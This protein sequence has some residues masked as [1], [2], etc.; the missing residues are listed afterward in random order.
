MD[1]DL[2][3][4]GAV[5]PHGS[6]GDLYMTEWRNFRFICG[7]F[8]RDKDRKSDMIEKKIS[9]NHMDILIL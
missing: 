7:S 8:N 9:L 4:T 5:T 3:G 6:V 1:A 2:A